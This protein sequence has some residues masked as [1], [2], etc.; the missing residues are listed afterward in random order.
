MPAAISIHA[1]DVATCR[2]ARGL[3]VQLDRHDDLHTRI[4]EGRIGAY[5]VPL[6]IG[7]FFAQTPRFLGIVAF[8]F[9]V[10]DAARQYHP[11][12][13]LTPWHF[14]LYRAA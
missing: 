4:A 11:P 2:M 10:F 7:A 14:S 3:H 8:R 1:V 9:R 13:K 6:H 12:I 5:E